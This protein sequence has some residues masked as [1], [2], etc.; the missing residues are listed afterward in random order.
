[1]NLSG[2][3]DYLRVKLAVRDKAASR[4]GR[5]KEYCEAFQ[6]SKTTIFLI[7]DMEWK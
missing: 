7:G 1:M 5:N 3:I 4:A 2:R 6:A